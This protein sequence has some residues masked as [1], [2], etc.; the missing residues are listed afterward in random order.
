MKAIFI[1]GPSCSGKSTFIKNHF[2]D[3]NIINVDEQYEKLLIQNKIGTN[4]GSF[5]PEQ[6]S[7]AGSLMQQSIKLTNE[8]EEQL[9]KNKQDIL[10]DTVGSSYKRIK[11]KVNK[12]ETIGYKVLII[13]LYIDPKESLIRNNKRERRL[14]TSSVLNSWVKSVGN[15]YEYK[16]E[17]HYCSYIIRLDNN[18]HIFN[19]LSIY[20]EF[21]NPVGKLK[22]KEDLFKSEQNKIKTNQEI[23]KLSR[24]FRHYVFDSI[25]KVKIKIDEFNRK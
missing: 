4:V 7:L 21:P 13:F 2:P 18:N 5:T 24:M 16:K 11:E 10:F 17:L 25:S 19:P 23:E 22:S 9:I 15:I 12:L 14:I 1:L 3:K 20:K 8:K 6:L